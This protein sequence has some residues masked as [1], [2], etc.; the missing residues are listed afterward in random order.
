NLFGSQLIGRTMKMLGEC[1]DVLQVQSNG[2]SS[3]VAP[4][5]LFQHALAKLGHHN[6]SKRDDPIYSSKTP[7]G[8]SAAKRLRSTSIIILYLGYSAA[9]LSQRPVSGQLLDCRQTAPYP[10]AGISA[11]G[12]R[13]LLTS[14]LAT[15]GVSC[16]TSY[17]F[18]CS[19]KA[20]PH[21]N[22]LIA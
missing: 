13:A 2:S 14:G 5:E 16:C 12:S 7:H 11:S 10:R 9:D 17:P 6:A 19:R 18:T 3:V 22:F 21:S 8:F 20:G 4:L 1:S 15:A